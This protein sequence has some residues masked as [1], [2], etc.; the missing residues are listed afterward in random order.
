MNG[1]VKWYNPRKGYGFIEG[2][3]G[4]DIFIHRTSIPQGIFLKEEDK[5]EYEIEETDK[6][7][8]AINI[9]KEGE[10]TDKGPKAVNTKKEEETEEGE[11]E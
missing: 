2:E 5:V 6:G 1:K 10:E 9:K 4:K 8:K 7:P 11:E 3:D